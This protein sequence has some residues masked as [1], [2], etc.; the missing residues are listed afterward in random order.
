MECFNC[1]KSKLA[2]KKVDF[3]QF[4]MHFGKYDVL[5][6]SACDETVFEGKVSK[7]I[8]TRA[9]ELGVWGL[10]RKTLIGT[11]GSSLD[12]KVPKAIA[13]FLGLKKGREV[14]IEPTAKNKI[15]I[16]IL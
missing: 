15:E 11:S 4:G 1:G 10:S 7:Q 14:M 5:V 2:A 3:V 16:T 12:V 6:C 8:E 9:K 13:E